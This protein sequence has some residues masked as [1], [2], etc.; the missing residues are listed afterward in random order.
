MSSVLLAVG[1]SSDVGMSLIEK[2]CSKYDKVV[3]HYH[4]M[5]DKLKS[6]LA[7][8]D[9]VVG[10]EADLSDLDDTRRL[11]DRII[12]FKLV[13]THI[14]HLPALKIVNR[15]FAKTSWQTYE[16]EINVSVRSAVMILSAFLP[17]MAKEQF[18]RVV[19]MLSNAVDSLPPK[20]NTDYVMVK[21]AL[22]GLMKSLAVEYADKGIAINGI[23]P[24]MIETKFVDGLHHSIIE[25]HAQASPNGR[26]LT[27]DDVIP[28][29]EFLLSDG[30]GS[31]NGHNILLTV[32]R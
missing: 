5:N 20:Y 14:V 32:G 16:D 2:S 13:P 18:G 28:T 17:M 19:I 30:S 29:I 6:M 10:I 22:L 24:A 31:I 9:N 23:S 11:I 26:N 3:C 21:Y 27:L 8:H 7:L 15:K 1:G 25:N 4:H 12:E